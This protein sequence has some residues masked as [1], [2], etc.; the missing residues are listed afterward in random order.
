MDMK[1]AHTRDTP[2]SHNIHTCQITNQLDISVV[3]II[4]VTHYYPRVTVRGLP[5]NTTINAAP[6]NR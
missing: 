4:S 5:Y 1:Y 3:G 6:Y 2:H